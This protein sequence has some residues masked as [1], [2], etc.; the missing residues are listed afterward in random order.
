MSQVAFGA[1]AESILVGAQADPFTGEVLRRLDTAV[2][3]FIRL[4]LAEQP[5]R[6]NRHGVDRQT[7]IDGDQIRGER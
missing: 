1:H 7:L 2:D 4:R 6:K 3:V 5:A